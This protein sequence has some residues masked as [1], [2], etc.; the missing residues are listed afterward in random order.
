MNFQQC[1]YVV[2]IAEA[3]SFSKAAKRLFVSQPN[4]SASIHQLEQELG[5][6]LFIR[7]NTGTRL[8]DDGFD[9]VKYAKRIIG[10]LDLLQ[11]RYQKDFKKSFTVASHHYDFLSQPL[12]S[13]AKDFAETYQEFQLI[14]TTTNAI[15]DSVASYQS[16]LG[17]LYLDDSNKS[18]LERR[19]K[20]L[21]LTFVP[22]G[23]FPTRIFVSK[24]HPLASKIVLTTEDLKRYT[25]IRFSHDG[26]SMT[27]DED[28]L[29]LEQGQ[30]V[31]YSNDRGSLMNMLLATDAYASGLGIITGFVKDQIKLIPLA[32]SYSHTLGYIT[33]HKTKT[34][35]IVEAFVEAIRYELTLAD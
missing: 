21:D 31:I 9:F 12:A 30:H 22:L 20:Q 5:V 15:I 32:D 11:N 6:Q 19:L 35:P 1:R 27:F 13:I 33:S 10:E 8:T 26:S 7:S 14:E 34:S 16:D 4:L 17:I 23:T 2:A 3:G 29:T 18:I 28:P 24:H 25:Q